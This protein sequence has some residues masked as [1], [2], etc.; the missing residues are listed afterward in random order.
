[1]WLNL[2]RFDIHNHAM[3]MNFK[4]WYTESHIKVTLLN[5]KVSLTGL[6]FSDF[7]IAPLCPTWV[8]RTIDATEVPL[9][10]LD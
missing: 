3:I 9:F 6:S 2:P 1:M 10:R 4:S 7:E 8:D 5:V